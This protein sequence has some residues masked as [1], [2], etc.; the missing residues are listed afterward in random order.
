MLANFVTESFIVMLLFGK[1]TEGNTQKKSDV[2]CRENTRSL[3][4]IV[5]KTE[6]KINSSDIGVDRSIILQERQPTYQLT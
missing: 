4:N 5:K 6:G 1:P 3:Q 2:T